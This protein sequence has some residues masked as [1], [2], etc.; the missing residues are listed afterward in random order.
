MLPVAI[1][2][3]GFANRLG[4]IS[5]RTA[6]SLI[7]INGRPFIDWQI[8]LL[9]D[10]GYEHFVLCVSHMSSSIIDYLG[11]GSHKG[12][13]I[14]YSHDGEIQLG[15]GGAIKKATRILGSSFAVINGDSYLPIDYAQVEKNFELTPGLALMTVYKNNGK[16]D[17]SNVEFNNNEIVQYK[18]GVI[19]SKMK[20]IDFGLT[21]FHCRAFD[22]IEE[23]QPIDM[24]QICINLLKS[25][26]LDGLEVLNRFYEIG[27]VQGIEELSDYLVRQRNEL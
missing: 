6:K 3:G 2:A 25:K 26:K 10:A 9:R 15:T 27:S 4:D 8:D 24:S 7:N 19:D 18:K 22:D 12:I 21:Y 11:D 16:F 14:D 5:I 1:L 13:K 20:H 17:S 23:N